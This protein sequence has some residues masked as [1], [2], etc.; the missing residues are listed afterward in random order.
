MHSSVSQGVYWRRQAAGD[1]RGI[2]WLPGD[3]V[4]SEPISNFLGACHQ[5]T[6]LWLQ[7]LTI[8]VGMAWKPV[9]GVKTVG[10]RCL[11]E[12]LVL[13]TQGVVVR[14]YIGSLH[15]SSCRGWSW[16]SSEDPG[17]QWGMTKR[18]KG[19]NREGFRW[20]ASVNVKTWRVKSAEGL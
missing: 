16:L 13:S 8:G 12:G 9:I 7:S 15:S 3:R 6:V 10:C 18:D 11:L 17:L 20:L 2:G 1:S 19:R 4:R 5:S 14:V